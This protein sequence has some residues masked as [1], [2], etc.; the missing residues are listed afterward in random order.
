MN[1]KIMIIILLIITF[2]AYY[3]HLIERGDEHGLKTAELSKPLKDKAEFPLINEDKDKLS[4]NLLEGVK[5]ERLAKYKEYQSIFETRSK[6]RTLVNEAEGMDDATRE[7]KLEE[8][9][10]E[11]NYLKKQ[12]KISYSEMLMLKLALLKLNP[13]Q[14]KAKMIGEELVAEYKKVA[15]ERNQAFINNPNP[16][17]KDYKSMEKSIVSEVM[18]ME[19]FPDGLSREEYLARRLAEARKKAYGG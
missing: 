19:T 17:F 8:V 4:E 15:D 16:Q 10:K 5:D 12:D 14:D 2:V 9:E 7:A 3:F 18:K 11:L 13:D 1:R 6:L